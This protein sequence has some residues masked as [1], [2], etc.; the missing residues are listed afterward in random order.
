MRKLALALSLSSAAFLLQAAD[1]AAERLS[2]ASKVFSEIMAT[3]DKGIPQDL[4]EKAQCIIIVPGMKQ[5]GFVLGA[6]FGRG[7]ATCRKAGDGWGAPAAERVEG[8]S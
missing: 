2:D 4:L 5:A 6:K 1:T 7:F 8:G 3:P